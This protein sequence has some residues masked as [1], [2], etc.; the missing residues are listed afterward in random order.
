MT[1]LLK[2]FV[3]D[4][5]HP[6][7]TLTLFRCTQSHTSALFGLLSS[8]GPWSQVWCPRMHNSAKPK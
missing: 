7:F 8:F 4:G 6:L 1:G 5:S 3:F 2:K